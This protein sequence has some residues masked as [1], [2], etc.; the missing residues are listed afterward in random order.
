MLSNY[1]ILKFKLENE[2]ALTAVLVS[3]IY[4]F[5]FNFI[6]LN[7]YNIIIISK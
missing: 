7:I 6:F 3:K 5:N 4:P 2:Y 1:F